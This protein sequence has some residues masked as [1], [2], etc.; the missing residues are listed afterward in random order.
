MQSP[1]TG[2][3]MK[4]VMESAKLPFRKEE[5]EV[6]YHY[7]LCEDSGE[8][9]TDDILDSINLNQVYNQY[10]ERYGIPFPDEIKEIREQYG[11]SASK[12][13]LILGFG[14]N[15]YRLYETGE[16]PSVANGRL[17]LAIRE[18]EDFIKQVKASEHL[19]SL[20]ETEKF[21]QRA[22]KLIEHR[23][24]NLWEYLLVR[25][26]T[27][28]DLPSEYS[29][30]HKPDFYKVA[31]I[32]SYF[33]QTLGVTKT[34]LNKL[35]FYADFGCYKRTGYSITG[36]EY[37]AIK[38]GP[39]PAEYD[40]LYVKLQEDGLVSIEQRSVADYVAESFSGLQPFDASLFSAAELSVMEKVRSNFGKISTS[41]LVEISHEEDAWIKNYEDRKLISYQKHA[42]KLKHFS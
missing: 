6:M 11:V 23:E 16:I 13:S 19:L 42:F 27:H 41:D 40:K 37:R 26:I 30:F 38:F 29:G 17:I 28:D 20:S 32:I 35:L 5:F 4:L 25:Q 33:S 22:K 21:E 1:I 15:Q 2:K 10:R 36:L 7:Y 24:K 8:Q 39:V 14:A 34:K 12:M 3:E 18:P 31:Q 9:F